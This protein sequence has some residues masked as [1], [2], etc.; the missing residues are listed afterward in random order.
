[1]T[2]KKMF[3]EFNGLQD[4]VIIFPYRRIQLKYT[5]TEMVQKLHL[6]LK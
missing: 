3:N 4:L 1:M 6:P 2:E 5:P